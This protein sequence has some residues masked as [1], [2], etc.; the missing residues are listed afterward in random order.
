MIDWN[1]NDLKCKLKWD[2]QVSMN[3]FNYVGEF[4]DLMMMWVKG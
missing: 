2:I 3:E 4:P 1:E